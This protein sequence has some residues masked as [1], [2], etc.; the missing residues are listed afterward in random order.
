MRASGR[1]QRPESKG[2]NGGRTPC[3]G[4]GTCRFGDIGAWAKVAGAR[5][6]PLGDPGQ[7]S[8]RPGDGRAAVGLFQLVGGRAHSAHSLNPF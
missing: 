7:N 2:A 4:L 5:V 3:H 1:L 8:Q 6:V